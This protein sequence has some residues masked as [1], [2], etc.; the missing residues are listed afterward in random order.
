MGN[1]FIL[2]KKA[3]KGLVKKIRVLQEFCSTDESRQALQYIHVN[4]DKNRIEASDGYRALMFK[5]TLDLDEGLY[6]VLSNK[7]SVSLV[8]ID[9]NLNFPSIDQI[10]PKNQEWSR[11]LNHE[12]KLYDLSTKTDLYKTIGFF[13]MHSCRF[14]NYDLLLPL[15]KLDTSWQMPVYYCKT[16]NNPFMIESEDFQCVVMPVNTDKWVREQSYSPV[17]AMAEVRSKV[18]IDELYAAIGVQGGTIHQLIDE[19]KRLK[20]AGQS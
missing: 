19:V 18:L 15:L 9:Q 3:S 1:K 2:D 10:L 17:D 14:F 8:Q 12:I 20:Q 7:T 5:E 16:E 11:Y 6:T 4:N 13:G